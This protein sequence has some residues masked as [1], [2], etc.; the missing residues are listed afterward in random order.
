MIAAVDNNNLSLRPALESDWPLIQSWLAMPE[1][2]RWW[3]SSS[4]AFA[5][6]KIVFETRSAIA[7]IIEH[8]GEPVGYAHAIDASHW[9]DELP[10]G[11]PPGTWDID[12]FIASTQ[13]RG[14]GIGEQV[15]KRLAEEVFSTTLAVA[16]SVFVSVRNERAIRGYENAGFHWVK[17]WNDPIHGASWLLLRERKA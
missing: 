15:V 16:L 9:G 13:H 6:I 4:A 8:D 3:G 14:R 12:L 10:A 1:V 7:R 11:L 5:E 2:S 17:V